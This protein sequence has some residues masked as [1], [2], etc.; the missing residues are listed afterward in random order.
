MWRYLRAHIDRR[1]I[2]MKFGGA[3]YWMVGNKS[4]RFHLYRNNFSRVTSYKFNNKV[5]YFRISNMMEKPP[6][7]SIRGG[8]SPDKDSLILEGGG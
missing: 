5:N 6:T 4:Y 8:S 7:R 2:L 1:R 3:L